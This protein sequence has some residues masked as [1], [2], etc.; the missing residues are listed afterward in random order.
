M[1]R[2]IP[3]LLTCIVTSMLLFG[4]MED[5]PFKSGYSGYVPATMQDGWRISAPASEGMDPALIEAAYRLLHDDDRYLMA[6]S[7][8]VIR[9][10]AIV[11]EAYPHDADD[12]RQIQNLQSCTKSFT[13]ILAGI[14]LSRGILDKVDQRL[15]GIMPER[16]AAHPLHADITLEDA[17]TMRGGIDFV[18]S[19]HT[20]KLYHSEGSSVDF[21]LSLPKSYPSGLV[22][23][24]NDGLPH[25][26]SAA[27]EH[28]YG[29]PLS[30]FADE[31][32]FKPLGITNWKWEATS[33][34]TSMGAVSLYL[35]P[36]DAA[37]FGLLLARNGS[38]E[39]R[40][41]VDSTWIARATAMHVTAGA[42]GEPYGYYFWI[43]PADGAYTALGH[44]GQRIMVVPS[45][46]LVIVYTAWPYTSGEFFDDF[47]EIAALILRSCN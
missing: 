15:S 17:L 42:A 9:N 35:T 18:N 1:R 40:R 12:M 22:F 19:E 14:A 45:K 3:Q 6:R 34:G 23:H 8:I 36:R 7:L 11:A 41:I 28:R 27:I 32:L 46:N 30:T 44:G 29:R 47:S 31:F 10:G 4:C 16:F 25:L 37:K 13:S 21:V 39:G 26:V 33:D 43:L 38:W 24:Y 20:E 2:Q 5:R